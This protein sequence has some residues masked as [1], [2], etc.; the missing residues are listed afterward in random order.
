[1]NYTHGAMRLLQAT[2]LLI[3]LLVSPNLQAEDRPNP[4][5]LAVAEAAEAKFPMLEQAL[6]DAK[7]LD[8]RPGFYWAEKS[9]LW[10]TPMTR[11]QRLISE[12]EDRIERAQEGD[13]DI[14]PQLLN[15]YRLS[16]QQTP[17]QTLTAVSPHKD[18]VKT[19]GRANRHLETIAGRIIKAR[20]Y[21]A[22][23]ER[24]TKALVERANTL[25]DINITRDWFEGA[26]E[27]TLYRDEDEPITDATADLL[28]ELIEKSDANNGFREGDVVHEL[29]KMNPGK[30]DLARAEIAKATPGKGNTQKIVRAVR[31]DFLSTRRPGGADTREDFNR[32]ALQERFVRGDMP[33]L[34]GGRFTR[35]KALELIKSADGI[36]DNVMAFLTSLE[37]ASKKGD[38]DIAEGWTYEYV[39]EQLNEGKSFSYQQIELAEHILDNASDN[40]DME[41][42]RWLNFALFDSD[43][44]EADFKAIQYIFDNAS[45]T[46][47]IVED[48]LLYEIESMNGEQPNRLAVLTE[49]FGLANELNAGGKVIIKPSYFDA[50]SGFWNSGDLSKA[51]KDFMLAVI[52]AKRDNPSM[53]ISMYELL[54]TANRIK[55]Y[56]ERLGVSEEEAFRRLNVIFA[57][58]KD[59]KSDSDPGLDD[60]SVYYLM[61]RSN[62]DLENIAAYL[63]LEGRKRNHKCFKSNG[64]SERVVMGR[65]MKDEIE[66]S[67]SSYPDIMARVNAC[68]AEE[69]GGISPLDI[70]RKQRIPASLEG[71]IPVDGTGDVNASGN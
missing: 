57:A 10:G 12:I 21:D 69:F 47:G 45:M 16:L 67:F 65:I 2:L 28:V 71:L 33:K 4:I 13:G 11:K 46:N 52:E 49:I 27:L 25:S 14:S 3:S 53:L 55:D 36:T 62:V 70:A 24:I 56:A 43:A 29:L 63:Q 68:L 17:A 35:D 23:Q 61:T 20:Q 59:L 51:Q 58:A 15:A 18:V 66:E 64:A 38:N 40:N 44:T 60:F 48:K 30:T 31:E 6:Q 54:S 7:A 5:D 19:E 22:N 9:G 8:D 42:G 37:E 34:D 26:L 39:L 1:M 32:L 41:D 50:I